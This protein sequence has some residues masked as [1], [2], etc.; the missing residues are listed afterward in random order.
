MHNLATNNTKPSSEVFRKDLITS[1]SH[2]WNRMDVVLI[3]M[4]VAALFQDSSGVLVVRLIRVMREDAVLS[5]PR[6]CFGADRL[7]CACEC[8]LSGSS[9]SCGI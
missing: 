9:G 6:S 8:R 4:S 5:L 3:L 2:R 1:Y 7:T